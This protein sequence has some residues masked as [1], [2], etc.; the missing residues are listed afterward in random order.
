MLRDPS[1][2]L[3]TFLFKIHSS[4]ACKEQP[5]ECSSSSGKL[6]WEE[7]LVGLGS[8]F[9]PVEHYM[10]CILEV[11]TLVPRVSVGG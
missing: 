6:A 7:D 8:R 5:L 4:L 11:G 2:D 9:G 10:K 3:D 1:S